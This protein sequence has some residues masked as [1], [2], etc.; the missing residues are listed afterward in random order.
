MIIWLL[1]WLRIIESPKKLYIFSTYPH[2]NKSSSNLLYWKDD[3]TASTS[4]LD[5]HGTH[6]RS[7]TS[8]R[9]FA[10][11]LVYTI[12]QE[13]ELTVLGLGCLLEST[14]TQEVYI[15][16]LSVPRKGPHTSP[17]NGS[18]FE[19][20]NKT[21]TVKMDRIT[22]PSLKTQINNS[23]NSA[24]STT[25]MHKIHPQKYKFFWFQFPWRWIRKIE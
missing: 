7:H 22:Y 19:K 23:H 10:T 5:S 25:W 2:Q 16:V 9:K 4:N 20:Q 8:H 12:I 21:H 18:E 17:S 1:C 3:Q 6:T 14:W 24:S 13:K 11:V 15:Y